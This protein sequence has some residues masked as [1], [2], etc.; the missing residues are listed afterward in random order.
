ML[1]FNKV[2]LHNFGSYGHTEVNLD[3]KGFCLV[4]GRNHYKKDNAL[5]NGSG[6]S[7]LWSAICFALTGETIGGLTKNLKNINIEDDKNCF[8]T[9]EFCVGRDS[10]IITRIIEPKSDMKIFKNDVDVSGKGIRESEKRL[11]EF[12][13]DLTKDL[14]ASILI[15][16]QGMP[17]KFSSFSPSGRKE[18]LEKLT[19]S[20]FMIEDIKNRVSTRLN[21]L[22]I[23]QRELDDALLVN[24]TQLSPIDPEI[25]NKLKELELENTIDYEAEISVLEDQI[26]KITSDLNTATAAVTQ[27]EE[28]IEQINVELLEKTTKKS[29]MLNDE[30]NSYNIKFTELN[31][32]KI[33]IQ[34]QINALVKEVTR[35]KNIKDI[36]PTCGQALIGVIKPSTENEEAEIARLNEQLTDLNTKI[37][38]CNTLHENYQ[39]QINDTFKADLDSLNAALLNLK[40]DS[41]L[42]KNNVSDFTLFLGRTNEELSKLKLNKDIHLKK[43]EELSNKIEILKAQKEK[44]IATQTDLLEAK[45]E[46]SKHLAVVKKIE[47]LIKRDFRG[48]LLSNIIKFIDK[49]AKDLSEIVFGTRELNIYLDGNALDISYCGKMIE[50]LSGGERT[51]VDLIIQFAIRDMLST[52]LNITSNILVLDEVTDFL[53]KQSCAAVMQLIEKELNTVESV[54]IISHHAETLDLPIDSELH[55]IKNENG[56]SEVY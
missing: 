24:K 5:S 37:I 1:K 49:K 33:Q 22:N 11:G 12:I 31:T 7:F 41:N 53:D 30:F 35:I 51:R 55:I 23:H 15:L 48:Y 47:T 40:K 19:K 25:T 34:S 26:I 50:A 39:L 6:K 21:A 2:I 46:E 3:N 17:N 14:I 9:L 29:E 45:T 4:S 13:P 54:F 44:L 32:Q 27:I 18:L 36:C 43:I 38:N 52:Y 42:Q 56:I 28:K 10:Y 16:G 20:D 8:V